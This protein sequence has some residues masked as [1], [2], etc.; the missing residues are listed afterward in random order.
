MRGLP[1]WG[2]PED[3]DGVRLFAAHEQDHVLLAL[4]DLLTVAT[5]SD[6]RPAFRLAAVRPVVP[7]PGR[8]GHGRL[9]LELQL[10]SSA[11][12]E[13]GSIRAAPP[14]RGWLRFRTPMSDLPPEMA[15]PIELDCSGLGFARLTLPLAPEGVSMIEAALNDGATPIL[16]HVEL[17]IAGIAPRIPGRATVDLGLLRAYLTTNS[18]TPA[19]L[20][21]KIAD[22]ASAIGIKVTD[23]PDSF[24]RPAVAEAVADH[25]RATLCEGP[26]APRADD[27]LALVL[28]DNDMATGKATIDLG[29][30]VIATR[31]VA[32]ALDPFAV[33]R[34][35][36][37]AAGGIGALVTRGQSGL[38][39]TGRHEIIVDASVSRP[40][41]G[42]LALGATLSFP[43]RPPARMHAIQ[44]DFELPATGEWVTRQI[45]LSPGEQLEWTLTG[46]AF[47][48]TPDGR[49]VEN[50]QG[51]AVNCTGSRALLRPDAFPLTFADL[52]AGDALLNVANVEV[53]LSGVR[54]SGKTAIAATTL[55]SSTS[56]VAL[57]VP[58]D[59]DAP[60]LSGSAVARDGHGRIDLPARKAADWRIELADLP[61][62][63]PRTAEITVSLPE[64]IPLIAVEV[65]AEDAPVETQPE[66]Y[67]FTPANRS[68]THRW[69][70]SDP[71]R[72][73]LCWRWRGQAEFSD[74]IE[75]ACILLAAEALSA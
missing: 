66:T 58:A 41:I 34:Q 37:A 31:M 55:T 36:S 30:P 12:T 51:A 42:P 11:A 27:G 40:C 4:P 70:C 52:E 26:L 73:G 39:P 5:D 61:R 60:M 18:A 54:P 25:I 75:S 9:D 16:A 53:S 22:D 64:G 57:A 62:Y 65:I 35:L 44:E 13:D 49:G 33:A 43:P 23:V 28:R 47:W 74:P 21:E 71:F 7:M 17:E 63:G 15:K 29:L 48:P 10:D 72:P 2:R 46:F 1:D 24:A 3:R 50:L 68:R 6:G 59:C 38:L 69:F 19:M 14:L 45:Q 8:R 67:A 56:R 32:V 20:A